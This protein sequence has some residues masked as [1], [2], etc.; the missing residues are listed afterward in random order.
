MKSKNFRLDCSVRREN[1]FIYNGISQMTYFLDHLPATSVFLTL[2]L[3]SYSCFGSVSL[4]AEHEKNNYELSLSFNPDEGR[5][6]G[7]SKITIEPDQ[8]LTLTFRG[9][10][11]LSLIHI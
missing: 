1:I 3:I 4:A 6:T 7:T 2:F 5:L 11:V 9:I 10:E 8:K